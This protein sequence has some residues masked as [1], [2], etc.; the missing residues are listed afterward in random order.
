MPVV[1]NDPS[2][3]VL[4]LSATEFEVA[5]ASATALEKFADLS[6]R[7]KVDLIQL[8]VL[9]PATKL[10]GH[11]ESETRAQAAALM[12]TLTGNFDV[13]QAIRS[14]KLNTLDLAKELLKHEEG[15]ICNENAR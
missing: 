8:G 9:A 10:L 6:E 1:V 13:R 14:A 5:G 3:L 4:N 12:Y 15:P 11:A 7:N 2:T